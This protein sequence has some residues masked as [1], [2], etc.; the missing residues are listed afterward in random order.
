MLWACLVTSVAISCPYDVQ[1]LAL[2]LLQRR[3]AQHKTQA[4]PATFHAGANRGC[5]AS[6][7]FPA[8]SAEIGCIMI[9]TLVVN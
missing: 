2:E 7:G 4:N 1:S 6:G 9:L 8:E 3:I 5:T